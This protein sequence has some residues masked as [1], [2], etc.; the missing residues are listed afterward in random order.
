MRN[1]NLFILCFALFFLS[2]TAN[3]Q[4]FWKISGDGLT[5]PSYLLG[6]HHLIEKE[7]IPGFAQI[8]SYIPQVDMVVGEMDM[9]KML[10][11]Q[12]KLVQTAIMKDSTMRQLLSPD[13]YMLVDIRMKEV[14]GRG[15][16]QMGRMKPA[17]LSAM[18]EVMLYMKQNNI[19]KEPEAVDIAVQ[20]IGKKAK[21]KILGLET[22]DQQIDILFNSTSLK[23]QAEMLVEQVKDKDE[24]LKILGELNVAYLAGDLDKMVSLSKEGESTNED[25]MKILVYDRNKNWVDQLLKIL[26]QNACFIAVGCLHLP[27]EQGLIQLFRNAGYTVEPIV[28]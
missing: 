21:K 23:H 15:L 25:D 24:S 10:S 2:L 6:T 22:I 3:A 8:Q 16:D 12:L 18:Y 11:M 14:V 19:K 7:Q 5:K 4:I 1:R 26:P 17:M 27:E 9:S 28:L 20:N 13:D